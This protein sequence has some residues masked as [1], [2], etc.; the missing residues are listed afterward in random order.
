M[1]ELA[2]VGPGRRHGVG[3]RRCRAGHDLVVE[4]PHAGD[5]ELWPAGRHHRAR[6]RAVTGAGDAEERA[7]G[8]AAYRAATP[9]VPDGA[10]DDVVLIHADLA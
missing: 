9:G 6:A 1:H 3:P 8:L 7:A 10:L 2:P 4:L 5:L